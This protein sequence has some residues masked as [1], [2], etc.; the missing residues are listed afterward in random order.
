VRRRV[1]AVLERYAEV[2]HLT[3][4]CHSVVIQALTGVRDAPHCA[5]VP[6]EPPSFES[7]DPT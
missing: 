4:V 6:C 5:V 1:G 7:G 2:G 3:V